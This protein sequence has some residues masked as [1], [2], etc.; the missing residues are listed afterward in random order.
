MTALLFPESIANDSTDE[1]TTVFDL[2]CDTL[3]RL[4][5]SGDPTVPGGFY[6]HD[7]D[8]PRERMSSL[9]SNDAHMS[10]EHMQKFNWCQCFA[11][12]VPDEA[13]G[14]AAWSIF[15]RVTR[16]WESE[17]ARCSSA[18]R[19]VRSVNEIAKAFAENKVAG[20]LTVEGLSFLEDDGSAE[21]RL[22]AMV[23]HGVRMATLTWNDRNA[24]GSGN[25]TTGGL[26]AFGRSMVRA[27]EERDIAVDASHLNIQ[28]FRDLLEVVQKPFACSHSNA[29]A[30]CGHP[31]N[32]EDWQLREVAD[33]GGIVGLNFFNG[34]LTDS[35]N[36][37][38][39][40]D[41]LR[42]IDR[43]L[44]VAGE[45]VLA[46]GSDY[47]GSDVPNWLDPCD[48]VADLHCLL[49]REFG[50][51]VAEAIFHENAERFFA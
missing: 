11:V 46:L 15:D 8:A 17:L 40:D 16:F 23:E 7:K 44:N 34:F 4:A 38:T 12:F 14:S 48:K 20:M 49:V 36:E 18:L 31:R 29:R 43:I 32:L 47:D 41:V 30:V 21:E 35:G 25:N 50:T 51:S 9:D 13:R 22:N 6:E 37:A 45:H 42:H 26:T 3:D 10:L 33:R 19:N 28:G 1:K 27:L 24:L 2:H 39:P 5:L